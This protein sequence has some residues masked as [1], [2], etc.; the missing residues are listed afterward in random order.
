VYI[1]DSTAPATLSNTSGQ[2]KSGYLRAPECGA[3][4]PTSIA[5]LGF[6]TMHMIMT[7]SGHLH[8]VAGHGL[9][10]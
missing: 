4:L 9:A 2:T 1:P 8:P 5:S 10:Q 3:G 6:P 7:V